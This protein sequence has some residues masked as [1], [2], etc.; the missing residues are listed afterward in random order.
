LTRV[1]GKSLL[2]IGDT[3]YY[4]FLI[5]ENPRVWLANQ[6]GFKLD[7]FNHLI[8][9]SPVHEAQWVLCD[10]LGISKERILPLEQVSHVECKEFYFTTGPW[11]YGHSYLQMVREFLSNLSRSSGPIEKPRIYISRERCSH[12][13]I[14]NEAI[15]M[16]ELARIGFE[17]IVPELLSFDEQVSLFRQA[18]CIIGAH[19]AG[20]TGLIFSSPRCR[21]IE[22]RN[23]TY[24]EDQTYQ[25]RGGNIFWRF[26]EFLGFGY[27]AFFA[28]PDETPHRAPGGQVVESVRLPN[29]T[30]NVRSF[31]SFLRE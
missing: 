16:S 29:L 25:A 9:F 24:H 19:G 31:M 30:V 5:E 10:R 27:H 20:L 23:P 7:D 21:L 4:H 8:M 26:S 1:K 15:L 6:A 3:N 17:K 12:G 11:N 2:L 22:I 18:E 13:K 14:T 28:E